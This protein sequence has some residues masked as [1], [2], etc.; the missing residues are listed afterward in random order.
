MNWG[1]G[2]TIALVLFIGFILYLVINLVSHSVELES[3]DYYQ[4]EINFGDEISSENN[5]NLLE[6]APTISLSESHIVIQLSGKYTFENV[7]LQLTRPNNSD[8]DQL[9]PIHGTKTFTIDKSTLE[10]GKYK[11][12]LTY[13]INGTAYLQRKEIYI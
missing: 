5:A 12:I 6:D 13:M 4:K 11:A 8:F 9:I 7:K 3:S 1:K 2:I 10:K